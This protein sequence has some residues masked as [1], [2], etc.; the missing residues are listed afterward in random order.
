MFTGVTH[1]GA[2]DDW[3]I[4]AQPPPAGSVHGSAAIVTPIFGGDAA[5]A[6]E[7]TPG[8]VA[9]VGYSGAASGTVSRRTH[10]L[11][12]RAVA[13]PLARPGL[14]AVANC[15]TT[16]PPC[17]PMSLPDLIPESTTSGRPIG[18]NRRTCP[19]SVAARRKADEH[20]R[21]ET[22]DAL[23]L[24]LELCARLDRLIELQEYQLVK[25]DEIGDA[26]AA[27]AQP[28]ESADA[29][30]AVIPEPAPYPPDEEAVGLGR[31]ILGLNARG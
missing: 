8:T 25:L 2:L 29:E 19:T 15:V 23:T 24:V 13:G 27:L 22:E 7:P 20:G 9:Y 12:G 28:E 14:S 10:E 4:T 16:S 6:W 26:V 31:L 3:L 5:L 18:P 1:T 11:A 21:M 17:A 30:P